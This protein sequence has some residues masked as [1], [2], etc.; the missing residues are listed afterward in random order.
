MAKAARLHLRHR[1]TKVKATRSLLN[2]LSWLP[3]LLAKLDRGV[4]LTPEHI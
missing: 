4:A 1:T 3:S 2:R